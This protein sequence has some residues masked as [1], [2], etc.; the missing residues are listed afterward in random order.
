MR[1]L[2]IAF[3]I[4]LTGC[5]N[6]LTRFQPAGGEP[7][8]GGILQ[9]VSRDDIRSLDP[10]IGYDEESWM[11]MYM[12]YNGLVT[13]DEGTTIVPDVATSWDLLEGGRAYRFHLRKDVMFHETGEFRK[14]AVTSSD[15]KFSVMRILRPETKSPGS[16]F[17]LHLEGAEEFMNGERDEVAGIETPDDSTI[18][19]RLEKPDPV[20]LNIL[21]MPFAY[22]IP[23]EQVEKY[24]ETFSFHPVGTGPF[25]LREWLKGS[26]IFFERNRDYFRRPLP[27]LDGIEVNIGI[28]REI[29]LLKFERGELDTIDRLSSPDYLYI[30]RHPFWKNYL[31]QEVSGDVFGEMMNCEME[32]FTDRRVRQAFNYAVN[33]EKLKKLR[34]GRMVLAHGVLPPTV[35]GYNPDLKGYEHDPE[36]AKRLLTEA[37]YPDGF[38]VTYW[39][40]N[41]EA[42]VQLAQSIQEDLKK[43]GV[44]MNIKQVTFP[45]YLTA[46]G[47][48]N[49]VAFAY[50]SWLQDYPDPQNFLEVKFHSKEIAEENSN[51]DAFYSNPEVDRLLDEARQE[52]DRE[53][54]LELYRKTEEIIV[55]DAPWIFEYHSIRAELVQPWVHGY[56]LHPVLSRNY[57][58]VWLERRRIERDA[59]R[60]R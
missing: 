22:V 45:T 10:A 49:R 38:E 17:F 19:F 37:G 14:R 51:N 21:A 23:E 7:R 9:V 1:F 18:I 35:P 11:G 16:G 28:T 53:K 4:L 5:S 58:K 15:F 54:R 41:D 13:Y 26:K 39:T 50:S 36:K 25:K 59:E 20:F 3:L 57:T 6:D 55:E 27:Y 60:S 40:T 2:L 42:A 43:I 46:T 12:L 30:K 8:F 34:N 29:A 52:L 56:F 31:L 47:R 24:P 33:K 48:R 32:P 44:T